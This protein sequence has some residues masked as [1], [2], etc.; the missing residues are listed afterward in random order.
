M[1][2]K[3]KFGLLV[4]SLEKD[5]REMKQILENIKKIK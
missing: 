3:T 1:S 5:I 2:K 4:D